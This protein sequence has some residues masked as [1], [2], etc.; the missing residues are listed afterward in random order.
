MT[1]PDAV[2]VQRAL[3]GFRQ[4][5]ARSVAMEVSSHGLALGRVQAVHFDTAVFTNLT[6]DHLD[7]HG[8]MSAYGAA[9]ASLFERD[10]VRLRVFNVDDAFGAALA[11]RPQF[12]GRIAC[13][14]R[15]GAVPVQGA[16]LSAQDIRFT[17]AGTCFELV[18]SF[19]NARVSTAL[20]GAFNVDNLLAVLAVLLGSGVD[21]PAAVRAVAALV[22][23]SGRLEVF[24]APGRPMVV[25]DYAHTPDALEK[26]LQVLRRHCAGRLTAVF[27]CGGDRDR[28]KRPLMGAVAARAADRIVLTNDNPRTEDAAQIIADIKAG[29]GTA[30]VTVVTDRRQ[31]IA[32]ALESAA[33][34]DV[35]LVAGKG[36]ETYQIVGT[37]SLHFS[38]QQVVRELLQVAA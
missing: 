10:D 24:A 28:G 36:H 11:A 35:V 22:A 7:F 29:T 21:L 8:D 34:G 1:T 38:D 3:A 30:E 25:V 26:A 2:T 17:A 33:A 23:P 6:R 31:A 9:K 15:A 18:S 27:G 4:R 20:V 32:Q 37:E 16:Y 12:A 5:G 13:S 19:G 14:Q